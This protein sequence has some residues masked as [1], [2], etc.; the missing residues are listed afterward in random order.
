MTLSGYLI[1]GV[2]FYL[3]WI[4][5]VSSWRIVIPLF[6]LT[7]AL[8]WLAVSLLGSI[9]SALA[10]R[11]LDQDLAVLGIN[12]GFAAVPCIY[13]LVGWLNF[14]GPRIQFLLQYLTSPGSS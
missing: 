4:A 6:L 8:F 3:S 12:F 5:H 10:H 2:A 13:F 14:S 9:F 1:M 7:F 11:K